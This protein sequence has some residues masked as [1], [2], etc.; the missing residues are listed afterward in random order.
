MMD[1]IENC[2]KII[3]YVY[4][5]KQQIKSLNDIAYNILEN[6]RNIIFPNF[7][8]NRKEKRGIFTRLIS[9]FIGLAYEGISSS[10][11]IR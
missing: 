1:L 7:L 9:G 8:E 6:E 10:L 4:F 2:R 5:Y 11:H 3:P